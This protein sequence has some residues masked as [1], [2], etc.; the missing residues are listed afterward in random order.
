[1]G[2]RR[3]GNL[4]AVKSVCEE[5]FESSLAQWKYISCPS[6]IFR[7]CKSFGHFLSP[8][9]RGLKELSGTFTANSPL[10]LRNALEHL[11]NALYRICVACQH[12]RPLLNFTIS[13]CKIN[14]NWPKS[15]NW[16]KFFDGFVWNWQFWPECVPISIFSDFS[17]KLQA[18]SLPKPLSSFL[19]R[20]W[21]RTSIFLKIKIKFTHF[22]SWWRVDSSYHGTPLLSNMQKCR[23]MFLVWLAGSLSFF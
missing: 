13:L 12:F 10:I 7:S 23:E 15:R 11:R 18:L 19:D 21:S 4:W 9:L 20:F 22:S 3:N 8:V 16:S 17:W 2:F 14:E 5:I 6:W 1:M